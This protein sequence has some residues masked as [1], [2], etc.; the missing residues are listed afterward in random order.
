MFLLAGILWVAL[1][2]IPLIRTIRRRS[3]PGARSRLIRAVIVL[4]LDLLVLVGVSVFFG[5]ATELWWFASVGFGQ[6]FWTE[7]SVRIVLFAIGAVIGS[8]VFGSGL[9]AATGV[10]GSES[11]SGRALV[12]RIVT[13]VGALVGAVTLGLTTNA[14]WQPLLMFA[15][16]AI[17]GTTDPVFGFDVSFYLFTL[18]FVESIRGILIGALVSYLVALALVVTITEPGVRK[19]YGV[20][21]LLARSVRLRRQAAG[22]AG[23]F[24]LLLALGRLL[25]IP[26]LMYSPAGAVVGVGWLEANV[27]VWANLIA[28]LVLFASAL[29]LLSALFGERPLFGV[30]AIRQVENSPHAPGDSGDEG[31]DEGDEPGGEQEAAETR[32]SSRDREVRLTSRSWIAPAAVLAGLFLITSAIPGLIRTLVL[33]PNEITL[34]SEYIPYHIDFT[35]EAFAI[36]SDN[37]T[38]TR[39]ET[40]RTVTE[41]LIDANRPTLDNIRLWDWRALQDNLEQQQEIRLYYEFHDV[42]IDRYELD[43]ETRQMMLSVRELEKSNLSA[44]SQTWVSRHFKYTHGYGLVAVP[45]NAFLPQGGPDLTVRNIPPASA[46]PRFEVRRPEV[47]YGERTDDHVYVNTTQQEFDYPSG[48]ENVYTDYEGNGGV[49]MSGLT[50]RLALAWR[51]D[52]YR[53][54][55][56]SYFDED[57]RIMFRRNIVERVSVIAPFLRYDRDPYPV[58][59]DDGR[60]VYIIDAHTTSRAYP[61]SKPYT[62]ALGAFRGV[63]YVRNSVKVVVDAYNGSVQFYVVTPDDPIIQTFS[64]VFPEL[65]APISEMPASLKSHIRYPTDLLTVQAEIYSVYHM[66]DPGVFYQREDVWEFATERYRESFQP[67]EPYYVMLQYPDQDEVEFVLMLPFT[68]RNKNVMNAWMAGR[69][70]YEQYGKLTVYTLP[71]GVEV[72]GPRQIEARI[73]QNTEMSRALSLWG[74][75]GS[76]VIRGNLLAIPLFLD[77]ELVIMFVEPIFLQAEEASLPQMQR[78]VLADQSRVVWDPDFDTA[79][80]RLLGELPATP[81]GVAVP[82]D[83]PE[84]GAAVEDQAADGAPEPEATPATGAAAPAADG[85]PRARARQALDE[86]RRAV[87]DGRFAEAGQALERLEQ[88]LSESGTGSQ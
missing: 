32:E 14:I 11:D 41:E 8:V 44:E 51:I 15:N 1:G 36:D 45:V 6:R 40:G 29:L 52:G 88:I 27:L 5:L 24:V 18:P 61:Y 53:Q 10:T 20:F 70:D 84:P 69:S 73:D 37:V 50:R 12:R 62:G 35:R 28:A 9:R 42:D 34:E 66:T 55:F 71:K 79:I 83:V 56:S 13:I 57:S 31:G 72:L 60:I 2:S 4:V 67:V 64:R 48:D 19:G 7:Y 49:S 59:T 63:N 86:Y 33:D 38:E 87:A 77:E 23:V 39:Y 47:Y 30:L 21:A 25:A 58:L 54:L 78:V 17:S 26:E 74:Q 16:R 43:G 22:L 85:S 46:D 82:D 80:D 3:Q 65:F 68:P 81:G 75:R 76:S